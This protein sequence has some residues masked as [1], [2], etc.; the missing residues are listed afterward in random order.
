MDLLRRI[1]EGVTVDALDQVAKHVYTDPAARRML[2]NRIVPEGTLKR[3]LR[4]GRL[5]P[6]EGERTARVANVIAHAEYVW[7]NA[8]DA[9]EFP[10]ERCLPRAAGTDDGDRGCHVGHKLPLGS[11]AEDRRP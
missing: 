5:T 4:E 7:R 2:M 6:A 11:F 3:R 9:R 8:E 1:G 10:G